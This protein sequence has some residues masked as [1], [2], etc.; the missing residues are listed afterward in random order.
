MFDLDILLSKCLL[1][2]Y[3]LRYAVMVEQS[4]LRKIRDSTTPASPLTQLLTLAL[5]AT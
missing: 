2:I 4:L 1:L 5:S 3:P